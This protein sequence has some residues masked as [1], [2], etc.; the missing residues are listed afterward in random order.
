MCCLCVLVYV[1]FCLICCEFGV[2]LS[3]VLVV[4][5]FIRLIVCFLFDVVVCLCIH[6][7]ALLCLLRC[8]M[9]GVVSCCCDWHVVVIVM[10][11]VCVCLACVFGFVFVSCVCVAVC[12]IL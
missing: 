2:W 7:Y 12:I 6:G 4:V 1:L 8:G 5:I 9:C 10:S 3:F 11:C